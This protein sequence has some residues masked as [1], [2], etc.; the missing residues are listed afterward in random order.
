MWIFREGYNW[1]PVN[2]LI[3]DLGVSYMDVFSL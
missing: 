2:I 3:F 1:S